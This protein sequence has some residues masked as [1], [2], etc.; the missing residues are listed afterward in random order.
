MQPGTACSTVCSRTVV[1]AHAV[2][3]MAAI[4]LERGRPFAH[5]EVKRFGVAALFG[6]VREA[7]LPC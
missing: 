2:T 3:W 7:M 1:R 5:A 6:R 4:V